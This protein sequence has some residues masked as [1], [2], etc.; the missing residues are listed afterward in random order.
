[1]AWG[2]SDDEMNGVTISVNTILKS[3]WDVGEHEDWAQRSEEWWEAVRPE[4]DG[5]NALDALAENPTGVV[6]AAINEFILFHGTRAM[7]D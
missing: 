6:N 4:L 3:A 5:Q 7:A 1:M 2:L